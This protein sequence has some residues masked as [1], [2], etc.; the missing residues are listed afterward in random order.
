M[1]DEF[2][3]VICCNAYIDIQQVLYNCMTS[4]IEE[5]I[6]DIEN[7][8]HIMK[9]EWKSLSWYLISACDKFNNKLNVMTSNNKYPYISSTCVYKNIIVL[10]LT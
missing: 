8:L 1:E 10:Y 4:Q 7:I 2:H 5:F 9:Y 6:H 3:F